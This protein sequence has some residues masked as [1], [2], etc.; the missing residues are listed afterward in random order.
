[1]NKAQKGFTL[2]ELV[3]VITILGILAAFAFPRFAA[4]EVEARKATINGLAG[5]VRAAATL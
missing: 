1:M 3:V 2:I 5:S 4:L